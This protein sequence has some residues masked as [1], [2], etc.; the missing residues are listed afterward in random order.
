M[1]FILTVEFYNILGDVTSEKV[2]VN[3]ITEHLNNTKSMHQ[4]VN[5]RELNKQYTIPD[6]NSLKKH[7]RIV[8]KPLTDTAVKPDTSS[9]DR[10]LKSNRKNNE[11]IDD[12][13]SKQEMMQGEI[14]DLRDD[15]NVLR[16]MFFNTLNYFEL[17]LSK[18]TPTIIWYNGEA[19]VLL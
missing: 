17:L 8:L 15:L 7:T 5:M 9:A 16:E 14:D 12:L 11:S 1:D 13:K 18:F 10:Q 3:K 4:S 2:Y 6:Y 19:L